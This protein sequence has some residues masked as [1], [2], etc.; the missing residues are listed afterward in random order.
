MSDDASK[1]VS[2]LVSEV[3]Q[4]FDEKSSTTKEED[5]F[6]YLKNGF[7]QENFKIE[8][9]N[10]PRHY[11]AQSL[12]KFLSDKIK[13]NPGKVK[14]IRPGHHFCFV[15]F[16]NE[17]DREKAIPMI[18]GYQWK[19]KTLEAV[20]STPVPDPMVRKRNRDNQQGGNATKKQKTLVESTTPLAHLPYEEQLKQKQDEVK[21]LLHDFSNQFWKASPAK[22]KW[23]EEQRKLNDG[24][25]FQLENIKA[26]PAIDGY[27][28]KCEFS[29]GKDSTGK[30]TIGQRFG[31]YFDGTVE[32]GPLDDL[33]HIS[34]EMKN[35]AKIFEKFL[36][37]SDL[38]IFNQESHEGH[39]KLLMVRQS[40]STGEIMLSIGLEM[41]D[42]T[43]EAFDKTKQQIIDFFTSGDGK[44]ANVTSIYYQIL[45]KRAP[46]ETFLPFTHLWG[47]EYITDEILGFKF[48][49]SPASFFQTNSAAAEVLYQKLID[50]GKLDKNKTTLLDV[51]C[52]IG[53]IGLCLSKHCKRVLGVEIIEEA[54]KDANFNAEANNVENCSFTCANSDD[55]IKSIVKG[56]CQNEEDVVA[57]VDPPRPGLHDR[58]IYQLR[59][60]EKIKKL[61]YVSCSPKSVFK[62]L[63][64]LCRPRSKALSGNPFTPKYGVAVDMFPHTAHMELVLVFERDSDEPEKVVEDTKV[65]KNEEMA[66]E[67][68]EKSDE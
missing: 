41:Q 51:C 39:W 11:G 34:K 7:T 8:V 32:V 30:V 1:S 37:Q 56:E 47:S 29:I 13:C 42:L 60:S 23:I 65:D 45:K 67:K 14:M 38:P 46:G 10:L 26:S 44:S 6:A 4:E 21:K 33:K 9:K 17:E 27:R 12:K 24:V 57:I 50:L 48:R 64:D 16:R 20:K 3:I 25:I 40:F 68:M 5:E 15:C 18:N 28:N 53:T 62:N 35:I 63:I 55:W 43:S 22:R 36:E 61:I 59:N 52:G 49:I 54:I 31:S 2:E 19:G 66:D 58:S